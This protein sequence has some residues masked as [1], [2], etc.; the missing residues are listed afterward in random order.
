[1][2]CA[3][4]R[5]ER[6]RDHRF[7]MATSRLTF[8]PLV[9]DVLHRSVVHQLYFGGMELVNR[10]L[11][12]KELRELMSVFVISELCVAYPGIYIQIFEDSVFHPLLA[13]HAII[14]AII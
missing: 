9:L 11:R 14:V 8:L 5:R 12:R 3:P 6:A 13:C 1:M 7:A 2:H 4:Q 10:P